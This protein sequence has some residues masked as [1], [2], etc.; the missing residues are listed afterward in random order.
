MPPFILQVT[1]LILPT[2][3]EM[4]HRINLAWDQETT[5]RTN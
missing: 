4:S 1:T 3:E 2:N 5:A